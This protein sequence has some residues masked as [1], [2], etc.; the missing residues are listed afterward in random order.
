LFANLI[1]AENSNYSNQQIDDM[2]ESGNF[3]VFKESVSLYPCFSLFKLKKQP[4]LL[5]FS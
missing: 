4:F 5:D 3:S 2:I 1:L